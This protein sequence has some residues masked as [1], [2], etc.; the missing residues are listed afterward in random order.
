MAKN[1]TRHPK[2]TGH[3]KERNKSGEDLGDYRSPRDELTHAK[4]IFFGPGLGYTKHGA[5]RDIKAGMSSDKAKTTPS[6]GKDQS[7]LRRSRPNLLK[8]GGEGKRKAV[9]HISR[10]TKEGRSRAALD[11]ATGKRKSEKHLSRRSLFEKPMSPKPK[12]KSRRS[13]FEDR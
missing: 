1:T 7:R 8:Q 2:S 10:T 11:A 4:Q 13:L 5:I 9:E 6:T 3:L 12:P